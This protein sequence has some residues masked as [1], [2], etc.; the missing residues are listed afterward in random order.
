MGEMSLADAKMLGDGRYGNIL[1]GIMPRDVIH[2]LTDIT[3]RLRFLF[4]RRG[5]A[6]GA[7]SIFAADPRNGMRKLLIPKRA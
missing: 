7:L 3:G 1:V 5:I 2:R 6:A 4:D